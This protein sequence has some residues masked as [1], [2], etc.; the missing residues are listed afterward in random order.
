[1]AL[2]SL[3]SPAPLDPADL[4]RVIQP[5]GASVTLPAAAYTSPEVYMWEQA[6]I[7]GATWVCAGRATD[8]VG[9]DQARAIQVGPEAVLLTRAGDG[10]LRAFSNTCRHR[11]HELAPIG[12]ALDARLIRCPYHSWSYGLDGELRAAPSLTRSAGF[13]VGDYP[14][15]PVAVDTWNGF[16]FVDLSGTAEALSSHVGNLTEVLAD[17]ELDRLVA[18]ARHEYDVAANWKTIVENYNECYH[19]SS[20]H[21]ELCEVT[22]PESGVD[23]LPT[24][25]WCGGTMDLKPHATTMSLDGTSPIPPLR[26]LAGEGLRRVAYVTLFPNLL[27]SAH[28]DY[29]LVHR[30]TPLAPDATRVNCTWLFA[31]DAVQADGFDPGYAVEFWDI[32]NREDWAATEG[33]NRGLHNRG[34]RQGPLSR[35]E[36]TVYQWLGMIT[37]AYAGEGLVVPTVPD[38]DI[39]NGP[40]TVPE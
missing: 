26:R 22:P 32:T 37:R 8:L 40:A 28:P 34:Y 15:V 33:V 9:P 19:C 20:I 23:I 7:F 27:L 25:M 12:D 36:A 17:H 14:L 16:V 18:V 30:L 1:M 10:H 13:D 4:D 2:N 21:P 29:V 6:A 38:R 11:G 39:P 35:W 5:F 31:P 24:G 3:G